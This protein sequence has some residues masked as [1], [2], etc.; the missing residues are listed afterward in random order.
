MS[1]NTPEPMPHIGEQDVLLSVMAD[2]KLRDQV[3]RN[4][5]GTTL[6]TNNGRNA[7]MDA[8]QECL[9]QAMYLKQ[10]L[11]EDLD[12]T[13][14]KQFEA[15][16]RKWSND[17]GLIDDTTVHKQMEKLFEEYNE[18]FDALNCMTIRHIKLE[19]GD[20][21]VVLA[22][23]C[24][25]LGCTLEECAWLAYDKIKD[26]KGKMVNGTFVKEEDLCQNLNQK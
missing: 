6:Q 13:T 12:V 22:N 10:R 23:I 9:D 24:T 2:L 21:Q 8:Y 15:A 1:A 19:I 25:Q 4:K 7:L 3:G 17:R 5:Y 11:M 18:L 20:M 26:R 14:F 16:I